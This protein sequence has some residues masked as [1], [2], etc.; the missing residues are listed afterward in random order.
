MK[1]KDQL[2]SRDLK[3]VEEYVSG[4]ITCENIAKKYGLTARTIQ[5]IA[6]WNGVVRSVSESN[7]LMAP[8]KKYSDLKV[9]K[10]ILK[11]RSM[12]TQQKRIVLLQKSPICHICN[13]M[14]GHGTRMEITFKNGNMNDDSYPNLV[15]TCRRCIAKLK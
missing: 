4:K 10:D 9:P 8:L 7:K 14:R 5:R 3:I 13:I 11:L 6:K 2:R 1:I 12:I 15:T